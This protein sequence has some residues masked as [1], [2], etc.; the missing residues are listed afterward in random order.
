MRELKTATFQEISKTSYPLLLTSKVSERTVFIDTRD[1]RM[2]VQILGNHNI[3]GKNQ[4]VIVVVV[5]NIDVT[6]LQM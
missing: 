3:A 6:E 5:L 1:N 2:V 4:N